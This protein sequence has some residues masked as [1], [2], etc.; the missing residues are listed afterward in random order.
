MINLPVRLPIRCG[1]NDIHKYSD[2]P[3]PTIG[4]IDRVSNDKRQMVQIQISE[5]SDRDSG[6]GASLTTPSLVTT[7]RVDQTISD[8]ASSWSLSYSHLRSGLF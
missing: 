5:L 6:G 7:S 4:L 1:R 8:A 2:L 3:N